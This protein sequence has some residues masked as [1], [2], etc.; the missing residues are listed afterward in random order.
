LLKKLEGMP[1]GGE[2]DEDEE[3]EDEVGRE[4]GREG[5]KEG[6]ERPLHTRSFSF[7]THVHTQ[8]FADED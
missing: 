3:D 1:T 5:G 2:E 8:L 4:G 7:P 6:T